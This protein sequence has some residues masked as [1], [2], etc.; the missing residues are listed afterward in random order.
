MT[1][2][3]DPAEE[4]KPCPFCGGEAELDTRQGYMT[5]K[6]EMDNRI[7]V[8]CTRCPADMGICMKDVE[9]ITPEM[10]IDLWNTRS[11]THEL[12]EAFEAGRSQYEYKQ[13]GKVVSKD[14]KYLTF[15]D[16]LKSRGE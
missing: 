11:R 12:R 9:D 14:W 5:Y 3:K 6:N 1:T 4:L 15:D 2:K 16:Y 8:Y 10:V 7:A 13:C